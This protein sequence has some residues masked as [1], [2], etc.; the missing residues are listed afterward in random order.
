MHI[1]SAVD[2]TCN[3]GLL[4]RRAKQGAVSVFYL[5]LH[6]VRILLTI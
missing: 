2:P 5:P 6:F 3:L 1:E 4:L